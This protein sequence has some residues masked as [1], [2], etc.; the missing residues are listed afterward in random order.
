[1]NRVAACNSASYF[2]SRTHTQTHF[3][4]KCLCLRCFWTN[5]I[6]V[7]ICAAPS[8]SWLQGLLSNASNNSVLT[9]CWQGRRC[10]SASVYRV[11]GVIVDCMCVHS[12]RQHSEHLQFFVVVRSSVHVCVPPANLAFVASCQDQVCSY[13]CGKPILPLETTL[14]SGRERESSP[15][16]S[17]ME[18][19]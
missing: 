8:D 9:A 15:A 16:L 14:G 19:K 10:V 17:Q 2:L 12:K 7:L 4:V 1:M 13:G 3:L 18:G 5:C 6:D 11:F